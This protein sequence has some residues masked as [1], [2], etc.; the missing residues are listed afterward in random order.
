MDIRTGW[1][2]AVIAGVLSLPLSQQ[3]AAGG[4][5]IAA[6]FGDSEHIE[7]LSPTLLT[8]AQGHAVYAGRKI[9]M[10]SFI[11][12]YSIEDT[13]VVLGIEGDTEHY[14][15]IKNREE[16]RRYSP[17]LADIVASPPVWH[18]S[19]FDRLL[20]NALWEAMLGL[21]IYWGWWHVS[22]NGPV[23][24]E[25]SPSVGRGRTIDARDEK[26]A[27]QQQLMAA[28]QSDP[29]GALK[30]GARQVVE[31]VRGALSKEPG[32]AAETLLATLG[33]LAGYAAQASVRMVRVKAGG[34][35]EAAV[36]DIRVL[37][38]QRY[39]FCDEVDQFLKGDLDSLRIRLE[40]AAK[41]LGLKAVP[42]IGEILRHA[43]ESAGDPG[44]GVL[45][46]PDGH[47]PARR[48]WYLLDRFWQP[49]FADLRTYCRNPGEWPLLY[50]YA[51]EEALYLMRGAVDPTLAMTLVLE[52]A[53]SM[54]RVDL[55]PQAA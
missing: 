35:T 11:L 49:M 33:A 43:G 24:L 2:T 27:L 52:S 1:R 30:L 50:F 54:A 36:F 53:A 14:Y 9:V 44:F 25:G 15:Q 3:A 13:G 6:W 8:D 23:V 22:R 39:F 47:R 29:M 5:I 31:R 38:H 34:Q 26:L 45:R 7:R 32:P 4:R 12:P 46:V 16:L 18:P 41:S 48:L 42:D 17:M 19:W 20:G 37:D 28:R 55:N 21:L 10:H 51:I 40:Q